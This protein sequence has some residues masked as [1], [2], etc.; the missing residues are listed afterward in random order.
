MLSKIRKKLL[1]TLIVEKIRSHYHKVLN[2]IST[3]RDQCTLFL[4]ICMLK[5]HFF[6]Y[7]LCIGH[8]RT[9]GVVERSLLFLKHAKTIITWLLLLQLKGEKVAVIYLDSIKRTFKKE[10]LEC[11][12]YVDHHFYSF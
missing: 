2:F 7:A 6:H 12:I 11:Y 8:S 3:N 9:L 1:L 10:L 4:L 5:G